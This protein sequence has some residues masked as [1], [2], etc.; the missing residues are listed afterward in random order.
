MLHLAKLFFIFSLVKWTCYFQF[1]PLWCQIFLFEYIIKKK[2]LDINAWS[3]LKYPIVD[4]SVNTIPV[5][6]SE[7]K[8]HYLDLLLR[9][10][11][12]FT[13]LRWDRGSTE[14]RFSLTCS[15]VKN[16]ASFVGCRAIKA[17]ELDE[18]CYGMSPDHPYG[19]FPGCLQHPIA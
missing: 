12:L 2:W 5:K 10:S 13:S 14:M 7:I 19:W 4:Q 1:S 11:C 17:V 6:T 18:N 3:L 15:K 9:G 16:S 8:Q